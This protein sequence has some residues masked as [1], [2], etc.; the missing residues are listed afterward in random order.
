MAQE[1]LMLRPMTVSDIIDA[2]IRIYRHNFGPILGISAIVELPIMLI[3]VGVNIA[4]MRSGLMDVTTTEIQFGPEMVAGSAAMLIALAVAGILYPLGEAA[5]AIGISERYLGRSID[6]G[7]CYRAAM[8]FWG[9]VFW[10]TIL[11]WLAAYGVFIGGLFIAG[12]FLMIGLVVRYLLGPAV[13]VVIEGRGGANALA[14]SWWLTKDYFWQV[15]AVMAIL[16]LLVAVISGGLSAPTQ[17]LATYLTFQQ[18]EYAM[19]ATISNQVLVSILN[20]VLR[21]VWMIATVL[22]YYD[23]RIRKEGFD[24]MMM[25]EALGRPA[26]PPEWIKQQQQ[27]YPT[28]GGAPPPPP[29]APPIPPPP[30]Y[31]QESPLFPTV[32]TSADA[33]DGY[34]KQSP[35][36]SEDKDQEGSW[37]Q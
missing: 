23:L 35:P 14:R 2:S 36:P 17:A 33:A 19:L 37:Q 18:S 27:L 5:L 6:V 15:F 32:D 3:S 16:F 9:R 24:L 4:W 12:I 8:P 29:G 25:A 20:L 21:P 34:G 11:Y 30:Q 22:V 28:P 1:P 31:G 10:T 13:I 26:P 7:E